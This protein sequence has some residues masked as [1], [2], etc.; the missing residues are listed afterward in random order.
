MIKFVVVIRKQTAMDLPTHTSLEIAAKTIYKKVIQQSLTS[1]NTGK[2]AVCCYVFFSRTK[3]DLAGEHENVITVRAFCNQYQIK[4]EMDFIDHCKSKDIGYDPQLNNS[5]CRK[6][7]KSAEQ[8][9]TELQAEIE[10]LKSQLKE[11]EEFLSARPV[12]TDK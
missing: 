5:H 9:I 12:P 1:R 7:D 4:T 2:V 8:T 10:I 6:K 11:K 3:S